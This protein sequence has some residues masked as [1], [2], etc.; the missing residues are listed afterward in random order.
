MSCTILRIP[1]CWYGFIIGINSR[2]S[3]FSCKDMGAS[4]CF[5]G[6]VSGILISFFAFST[7]FAL[8]AGSLFVA[9]SVGFGLSESRISLFMRP[10]SS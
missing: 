6:A 5:I 2:S 1:D 8:K 7:F 4:T 10:S 9:E 3:Y